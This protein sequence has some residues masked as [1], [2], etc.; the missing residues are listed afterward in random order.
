MTKEIKQCCVRLSPD[1]HAWAKAHAYSQGLTLQE[2]ITF[3]L[4]E[5]KCGIPQPKSCGLITLP[6]LK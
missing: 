3:L 5:E 1:L 2:Y 6:P 4:E